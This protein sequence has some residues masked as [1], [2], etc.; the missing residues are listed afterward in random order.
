MDDGKGAVR[1]NMKR[2]HI[3]YR[4]LSGEG[5]HQ[6]FGIHGAI[7]RD[8]NEIIREIVD[9]CS[10]YDCRFVGLTDEGINTL[11]VMARS[12]GELGGEG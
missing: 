2:F 8:A 11:R 5:T 12:V 7:E 9:W 4:F 3:P 1:A 10:R 6:G